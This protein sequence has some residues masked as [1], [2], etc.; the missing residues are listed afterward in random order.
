MLILVTIGYTCLYA[1]YFVKNTH[2]SLLTEIT[3]LRADLLS[4][5]EE[6]DVLREKLQTAQS[7]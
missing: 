1:I 4:S 2:G 7:K 5:L 6:V 3:S